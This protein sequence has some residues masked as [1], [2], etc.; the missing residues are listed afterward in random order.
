M[1]GLSLINSAMNVVGGVGVDKN[2]IS[3]N[4]IG[5]VLIDQGA[6]HNLVFGNYVGTTADG[7]GRRPNTE[8][9]ILL[10]EP[11]DLAGRG[12]SENRLLGNVVVGA[13]ADSSGISVLAAK[14]TEIFGN[15]VGISAA[16]IPESPTGEPL[17]HDIGIYVHDSPDT[18]VGGTGPAEF[19]IVSGNALGIEVNGGSDRSSIAGNRVGTDYEGTSAAPNGNGVAVVADGLAEAPADVT[20]ND[21]TI[22]GSTNYGM[23]ITG[24]AKRPTLTDNRFGTDIDGVKK[25]ANKIGFATGSPAGGGAAPTDLTFGPG[26]V[27]AGNR[28]DGAQMFGPG[29]VVKGNRIGVSSDGKPLGNDTVGLNV[30]GDGVL[31]ENNTVSANAQGIAI[32]GPTENVVIRANRIGTTPDGTAEMGNSGAGVL[33]LGTAPDAPTN[34]RVGGS[35]AADANVISGNARGVQVQGDAKDTAIRQNSIGLD[36]AYE[37][38]IPNDVGVSLAGGT[39]TVVGGALGIDARNYIARNHDA[40]IRINGAKQSVIMGNYI[41]DN[42]GPGV[43]ADARGGDAVIGYDGE[44]DGPIEDSNCRDTRCNRI[45]NNQG[46]GVR[47]SVASQITVR[48][49]RMRGNTGLDVDLAGQGA[50]ANDE[51]DADEWPNTPIGVVPIKAGGDQSARIGGRL[52]RFDAQSTLI[53]VYG[54]TSTQAIQGRPSG[55]EYLGTAFPDA[56]GEW[57]LETSKTYAAYGAVMTD[58][59]GNTGELSPLC[60]GDQDADALCDNWETGGI[61]YDAD[62]TPD[63]RLQDQGATRS[64]PTSSSRST[65][66]RAASRT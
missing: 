19:N 35:S 43:L 16:G 15:F 13:R 63:L 57:A 17:G 26:N 30:Q 11:A 56:R 37:N 20:V 3:G 1:I 29:A 66:R 8:T 5:L 32:T 54:F 55:G 58:R 42:E 39:N 53:D 28:T 52:D 49:N 36:N 48:G 44:T 10:T 41:T 22:A 2:V 23:Y 21:N 9:G 25:L 33:V 38:A 34:T 50:T 51:N 40:G 47:V 31:V 27:V 65:G 4:E 59:L 6:S 60:A 7:R 12:T 62:G 18:K 46:A 64:S 24:G 45:E 14:K 61:D